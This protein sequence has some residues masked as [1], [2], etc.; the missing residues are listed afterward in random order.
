M[1]I[2]V[3]L[4]ASA[5]TLPGWFLGDKTRIHLGGACLGLA[6]LA[7]LGTWLIF[8]AS[9][10]LS[11][12]RIA[13]CTVLLAVL[14]VLGGGP[15]TA[16]VLHRADG[17]GGEVDRADQVL[18]GGAWIGALER[19][20][21]FGSLVAGWPQGLAVVLALKGL[22]R[23]SELKERGAA[24]RFIIGSFASVLWAVACAAILLGLRR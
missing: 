17:D 16:A 5:G 11:Q 21:V 12:D 22:G 1:T 4:L 14:A 20:A 6:T 10:G 7:G 19:T 24:E 8:D 15:V 2:A 18:R 23:F 3:L 13:T 9:P